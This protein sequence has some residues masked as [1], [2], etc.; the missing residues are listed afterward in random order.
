MLRRGAVVEVHPDALVGVGRD[1]GVRRPVGEATHARADDGREGVHLVVV[2]A[3]GDVHVAP[4]DGDAVLG[5]LELGLEPEEAL[6]RA[7]RGVGLHGDEEAAGL[8]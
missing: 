3:D 4:G 7:E 8:L 6:V 2:V 5:A 1:R